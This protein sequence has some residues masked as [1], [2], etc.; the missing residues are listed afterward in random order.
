[1]HVFVR[2][3]MF[4][5]WTQSLYTSCIVW[6]IAYSL[7]SYTTVICSLVCLLGLKLKLKSFFYYVIIIIYNTF[8]TDMSFL[9]QRNK[10]IIQ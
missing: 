1:M 4:L 9:E 8:V 10:N 6:D 7:T 2:P 5:E 3:V